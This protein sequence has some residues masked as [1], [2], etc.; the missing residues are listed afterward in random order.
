M[1]PA[2]TLLYAA[3]LTDAGCFNQPPVIYGLCVTENSIKAFNNLLMHDLP[4]LELSKDTYYRYTGLLRRVCA[5]D[6]MELA[7]KRCSLSCFAKRG[8]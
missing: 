6:L 5:S 4:A 1:Y 2:C 8:Q 3:N 7:A